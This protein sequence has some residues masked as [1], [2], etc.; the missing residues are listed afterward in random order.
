MIQVISDRNINIPYVI[1]GRKSGEVEIKGS[2]IL[3]NPEGFYQQLAKKIDSCITESG[4]QF[5]LNISLQ[6]INTRSSK[7]LF[8]LLK[9][10]Q[11]KYLGK[12]FIV[13][14]WYYKY[15]NHAIREVGEM[16]QSL[17]RLQVNLIIS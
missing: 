1:I 5:T 13:I 4:K 3:V 10:L 9:G 14:N 7:W 11:I 6:R 16:F 8:H 15:D 2:S 17:L 12:K